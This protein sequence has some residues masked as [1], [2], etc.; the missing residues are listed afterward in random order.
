[1]LSLRHKLE[2]FSVLILVTGFVLIPAAAQ[3][4]TGNI[5]GTVVDTSE[6]GIGNVTVILTNVQMGTQRVVTTNGV[7]D[8]N[9]PSMPLGDY[10][11]SAEIA[12]FQKKITSGLNLQVDQTAVI[13]IVLEPGAVTQQVEVTSAAP[14]LDAQTSSLRQVIENQRILELPLNGRNP[15]ALGLL[16]GGVT[17][18]SGLV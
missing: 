14:L 15:F 2:T 18:F 13:R 9:A 11:I 7:G 10:Q 6:G 12:G 3:V 1:M 4:T 16:V 17:P 5:R 8:F